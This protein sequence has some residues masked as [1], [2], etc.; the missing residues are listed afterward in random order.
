M[1]VKARDLSACTP[2]RDRFAAGRGYLAACTLGLPADVTRDAL[3]RDLERWSLGEADGRPLL[4]C[5][6]A[7]PR[8]RR[9][10][11]R[12]RAPT[13]SRPA[14]RSRCSRASPPPQ[15]PPGLRCS[16][17][18]ATS[19]RSSSPFLA[20]G[21][22]RV[23]HV[24]LDSPR[25]RGHAV[26]LAPPRTRSCNPRRANS[27]TRHPSPKRPATAGA[28]ILLD[29]TQATGLDADRPTSMPISPSATPT[30]GSRAPRGA[31]FAVA[32]DRARRRVRAAHRRMV[33][34]RRPL[35]VV[36]RPRAAPRRGRH[37]DSRSPARGMPGPEP[38]PRSDSP[39]RSTWTTSVG[40]D[41]G[42]ANAFREALGP[43]TSDSAIVTW[44][45]ADGSDLAALTAAGVVAWG[46]AGWAR[47]AFHLWNDDEDVA[48]TA[49]TGARTPT[50]REMT[51]I[52]LRRTAE[53]RSASPRPAMAGQSS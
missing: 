22:L 6:R 49:T 50:P 47:V 48:L 13:A 52:D 28:L 10:A 14:R 26:D 44:P 23:R 18:T 7:R 30:S 29:T 45:D 19:R 15:R 12:H 24:P 3:R 17:S 9:D 1:N 20:R 46:R 5:T 41:V 38:R 21:D 36:L 8:S 16:A 33:L 43:R 32:S 34:G 25:R 40:H 31:A 35:G 37:A 39:R 27:P 42:L 51:R 4:G 53:G 11:A 2:S